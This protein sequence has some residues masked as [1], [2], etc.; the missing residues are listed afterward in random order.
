[1]T[2]WTARI[3]Q[4]SLGPCNTTTIWLQRQKMVREEVTLWSFLYTLPSYSNLSQQL[5]PVTQYLNALSI[6]KQW[7]L[8]LEVFNRS[9]SPLL[10]HRKLFIIFSE[11]IK[12]PE[13]LMLE[14]LHYSSSE[15]ITA[16]AF[17]TCNASFVWE[18]YSP[19]EV[20]E[21]IS[22]NIA[23]RTAAFLGWKC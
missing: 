21:S 1:M 4:Q 10:S 9:T 13:S 12:R 11:V 20:E 7:Q 15:Q 18:K 8:Q 6:W 3:A 2:V 5:Y 19:P 22:I 14:G 23:L 17:Y 16:I